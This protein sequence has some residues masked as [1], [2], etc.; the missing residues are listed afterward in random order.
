MF[1]DRNYKISLLSELSLL[2]LCCFLSMAFRQFH[3]VVVLPLHL[4]TFTLWPF[5]A[6]AP[7]TTITHS[8]IVLVSSKAVEM[9]PSLGNDIMTDTLTFG[10]LCCAVFLFLCRVFEPAQSSEPPP[11]APQECGTRDGL[12]GTTFTPKLVT[13]CGQTASESRKLVY[14]A[15]S[16]FSD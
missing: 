11:S 15:E 6:T 1:S 5:A 9:Q 3:C 16:C 4:T 8:L 10:N 12:G 13:H 7:S 14:C 2:L